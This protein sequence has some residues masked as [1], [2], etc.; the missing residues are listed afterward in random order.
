M[1]NKLL[2]SNKIISAVIR[3]FQVELEKSIFD[4]F[5]NIFEGFQKPLN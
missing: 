5:L 3:D 4:L 1:F 2:K